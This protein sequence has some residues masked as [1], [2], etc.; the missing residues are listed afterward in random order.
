MAVRAG[1]VQPALWQCG[2][3][4]VLE[5]FRVE[6]D[7]ASDYNIKISCYRIFKSSER[8]CHLYDPKTIFNVQ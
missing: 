8:K 5:I 6:A 1:A 3:A 4:I 7:F 2:W